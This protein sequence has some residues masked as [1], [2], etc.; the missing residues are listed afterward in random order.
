MLRSFPINRNGLFKRLYQSN[1]TQ[2]GT[3]LITSVLK[4]KRDYNR[5]GITAS[6]KIGNAVVRNRARRVVKESYRL[7]EPGLKTGFDIVFICRSKTAEV[8]MQDVKK[9][10]QRQLTQLE[11]KYEN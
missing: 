11:I 10:M 7:L 6:K 5:I 3:L 1:R 9:E 8:K 2:K 4:N